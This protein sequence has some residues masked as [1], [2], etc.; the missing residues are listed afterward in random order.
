MCL[1]STRHRL[2]LARLVT[3]GD[4]PRSELTHWKLR[5][6]KFSTSI[7]QLQRPDLRK[8]VGVLK[9]AKNNND[10]A[11]ST[12]KRW[13]VLD[14]EV[15][16][17]ANEEKKPQILRHTGQRYGCS[18]IVY[19]TGANG[20]PSRFAQ[21]RQDDATDFSLLQHKRENDHTLCEA[22]KSTHQHVWPHVQ[23]ELDSQREAVGPESR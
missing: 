9:E 13:R 18:L 11:A 7:E 15:A 21:Q 23:N 22:I 14:N 8:V 17:A 16:D 3:D 2:Q 4:G 20:H 19:C 6:Q 5:A 12:M 10:D 1:V